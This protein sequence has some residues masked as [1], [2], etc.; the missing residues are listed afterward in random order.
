MRTNDAVFFVME[1]CEMNNTKNIINLEEDLNNNL[2]KMHSI[3]FIHLDIKPSN[4]AY[5]KRL[6]KYVFLDFGIS[7]LIF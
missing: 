7:R 3:S 1:M 6:N 5:S 2:L 4:I